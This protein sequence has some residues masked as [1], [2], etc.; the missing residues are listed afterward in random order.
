MLAVVTDSGIPAR[1]MD[2]WVRRC[3]GV[4][5]RRAY[6]RW[7]GTRARRRAWARSGVPGQK[8]FAGA[9]FKLIFL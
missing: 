6:G 2:P 3:L 7:C 5:A 9:D 1:R 4:C 8:Q